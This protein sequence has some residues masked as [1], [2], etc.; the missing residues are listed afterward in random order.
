M[1]KRIRAQQKI[2]MRTRAVMSLLVV[3][4]G[5]DR[6]KNLAS[7]LARAGFRERWD[8]SRMIGASD[9]HH[10]VPVGVGS[11]SAPVLVWRVP[12]GNEMNFIQMKSA[13]GGA[14]PAHPE[15]R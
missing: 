12:R 15:D 5:I 13:L 1:Q 14:R 4:H 6:I 11:H 8:E 10:R 3:P 9:G 7:G 2:K